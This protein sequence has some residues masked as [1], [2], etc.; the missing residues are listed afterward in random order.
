MWIFKESQFQ[1]SIKN[2]NIYFSTVSIE[3]IHY[4]NCRYEFLET[5]VKQ[6]GLQM[7]RITEV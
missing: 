3:C 4:S 7:A 5:E 2:L 1:H 6:P